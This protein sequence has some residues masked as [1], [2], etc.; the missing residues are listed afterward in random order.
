MF[1]GTG[2]QLSQVAGGP[3]GACKRTVCAGDVRER[4]ERPLLAH[5]DIMGW[6]RGRC[7]LPVENTA[8]AR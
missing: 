3:G 5:T 2:E 1:L 8:R 6:S 4:N 7:Y